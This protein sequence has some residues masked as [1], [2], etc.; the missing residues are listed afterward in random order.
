MALFK[1]LWKKPNA[2]TVLDK[3]GDAEKNLRKFTDVAGSQTALTTLI[4]TVK[5]DLDGVIKVIQAEAEE[6]KKKP[7]ID[8]F[9]YPEI[10]SYLQTEIDQVNALKQKLTEMMDLIPTISKREDVSVITQML[11]AE[12]K[13]IETREKGFNTF[14]KN[15]GARTMIA[16]GLRNGAIGLP[17]NSTSMSTSDGISWTKIVNVAEEFGGK[18]VSTGGGVHPFKIE[19]PA[20]TRPIPVSSDV[21]SEAIITQ[22]K[23]QIRNSLPQDKIPKTEDIKK[24][25]TSGKLIRDVA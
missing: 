11:V 24:A 20:G 3:L 23:Q 9:L 13:N 5:T 6:T 15:A 12:A 19:F 8:S 10:D 4:T 18:L 21:K 17:A 1:L 2:N 7:W 14:L 16:R 25:I 22:M